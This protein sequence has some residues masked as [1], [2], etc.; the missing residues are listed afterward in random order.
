MMTQAARQRDPVGHDEPDNSMSTPSALPSQA[1]RREIKDATSTPRAVP[2]P[3]ESD[4]QAAARVARQSSADP[5]ERTWGEGEDAPD[6][7]ANEVYEQE[8][9]GD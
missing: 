8:D 5:E 7:S 9:V 6:H 4:A 2:R 1:T 3:G